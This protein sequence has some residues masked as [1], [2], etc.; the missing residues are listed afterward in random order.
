MKLVSHVHT[1]TDSLLVW[2][3]DST[4]SEGSLHRSR[5]W[6]ASWSDNGTS[7]YWP[8]SPERRP[9]NRWPPCCRC[10]EPTDSTERS[11]DSSGS[12]PGNNT[13]ASVG[14]DLPT[15]ECWNRM[16]RER[17]NHVLGLLHKRDSRTDIYYYYCSHELN[18]KQ[19]LWR[20]AHTSANCTWRHQSE[21]STLSRKKIKTSSRASNSYFQS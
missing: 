11:E 12:T 18:W 7:A 16:E 15:C 4:R 10:C 3:P 17:F 20:P 5:W 1:F 2:R 6:R 21:H 14:A 13:R 8:G 19:Q 9:P